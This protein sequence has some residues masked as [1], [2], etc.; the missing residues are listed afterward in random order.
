MRSFYSKD[1]MLVAVA[2][3]KPRLQALV[4]QVTQMSWEE[5]KALQEPLWVREALEIL[6]QANGKS[7]KERLADILRHAEEQEAKVRAQ[8]QPTYEIR[9][10]DC[11]PDFVGYENLDRSWKIQ[12][13]TGDTF[14]ILTDGQVKF[15]DQLVTVG[16]EDR[17]N[18]FHKSKLVGYMTLANYNGFH[19]ELLNQK[20][21]NP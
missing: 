19:R 10:W 11:D 17:F 21:K 9:I 8:P 3:K 7:Q 5:I 4:D 20:H 15:G 2:K 16:E 14:A 13:E 12:V 1:E 18:L 6:K